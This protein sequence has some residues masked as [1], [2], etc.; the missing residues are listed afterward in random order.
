MYKEFI[1]ITMARRESPIETTTRL[2]KN[3]LKFGRE[4][5]SPMVVEGEEGEE[6]IS[7][8]EILQILPLFLVAMV[9]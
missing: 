9:L 6:Y 1:N 4:S 7:G 8:S 5:C 2:S 3:L